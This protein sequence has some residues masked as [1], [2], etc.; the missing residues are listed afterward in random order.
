L[1]NPSHYSLELP[2]RCLQLI[3]ALW[4]HVER[5]PECGRPDAGPL[6]TTFLLAM[7]MPIIILP[8]ERLERHFQRGI[9][10]EG[11]ADD[12]PI[13]PTGL[14]KTVAKALG[15]G[16]VSKS[17]FFVPEAWSYSYWPEPTL[18]IARGLPIELTAR[19]S[20]P[21]A[22]K[23]AGELAAS[24]W[25]SVLR[26][27]LAH[28]GVSYLDREGRP[29]VGERAEMLCFVSGHKVD[30]TL[31]GLRCLRIREADFLHFLRRWVKWLNSSG[32]TK[33]MAA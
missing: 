22:H 1:G 14:A 5:L 12:G 13:N 32:I 10:E 26:N 21:S 28:G 2:D 20:T 4:P 15:G 30:N 7:A 25:C 9:D 8:V 18:N 23:S 29:T 16:P 31:I 33:L 3:N 11:Y 6:T 24:L 19:L 27:A 17:Y